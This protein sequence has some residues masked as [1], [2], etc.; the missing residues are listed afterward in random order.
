M[1]NNQYIASQNQ[2]Y[3]ERFELA[4]ERIRTIN[5]EASLEDSVLSE[6]LTAYFKKTSGFLLQL[7]EVYQL[8]N[9]G[10]IHKM[11]TSQLH[12]LNKSLYEDIEGSNYEKVMQTQ[13]LPQSNLVMKLASFCVCYTQHLEDVLHMH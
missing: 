11:T 1:T 5:K 6:A 4:S 8:V 10:E 12:Y 3:F 7:C 9:S 13:T 2:T